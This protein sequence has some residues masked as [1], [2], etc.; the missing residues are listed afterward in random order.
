MTIG[1][2]IVR[3]FDSFSKRIDR[4]DPRSEVFVAVFLNTQ[5]FNALSLSVLKP[6]YNTLLQPISTVV[7]PGL[8]ES[9]ARHIITKISS[10]TGQTLHLCIGGGFL[11]IAAVPLPKI[12]KWHELVKWEY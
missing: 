10:Y 6:E 3:H 5:R 12:G 8:V 4:N 7:F 2:H 11:H 1:F 9:G